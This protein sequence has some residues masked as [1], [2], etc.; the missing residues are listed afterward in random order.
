MDTTKTFSISGY[1]L[2]DGYYYKLAL[3]CAW[4]KEIIGQLQMK[5]NSSSK[6]FFLLCTCFVLV[7]ATNQTSFVLG[8]NRMHHWCSVGT[9]KSSVSLEWW[10]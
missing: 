8:I 4:D 6:G 5:M 2:C 7:I 3:V 9:G 10:T 1:M